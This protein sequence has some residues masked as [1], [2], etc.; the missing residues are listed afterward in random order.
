MN[1]RLAIWIA[2]LATG[3]A[4]WAA[5]GVDS[6]PEEV[7]FCQLAQN[8]SSFL[9]KRIRVRALYVYGFEL[10]MLKSPVCCPVAEPKMGVDFDLE[11]DDRSQKLF[12]KLDKGMGTALAVF[13]GRFGRI[14]NVSSQ[15][16]SGERF[17]LAVDKIETVERSVR[18]KGKDPEWVPRNCTSTAVR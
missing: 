14:S 13:V 2:L 10:Q 9:G 8:P 12:H 16:P 15:L 7:N 17:Q 3:V 5:D 6:A 18:W 1:F 11:M 4:A